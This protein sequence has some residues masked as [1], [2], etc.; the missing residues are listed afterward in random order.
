MSK[1]YGDI[2][3]RLLKLP[4][5]GSCVVNVRRPDRYLKTVRKYAPA[6]EWRVEHLDEGKV[7]TRVR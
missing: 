4:V 7:M 6:T 2:T 1:T 5:G 3:E